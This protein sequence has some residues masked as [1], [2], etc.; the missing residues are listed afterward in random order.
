MRLHPPAM[1]LRQW[2]TTPTRCYVCWQRSVL[3]RAQRAAPACHLWGPYW[4]LWSQRIS[5]RGWFSGTFAVAWT[6]TARVHCSNCLRCLSV[7]P[8]SPC[9]STQPF[10]TPFL[11]SWELVLTQNSA[12]LQLWRT[13]WYCCLTRYIQTYSLFQCVYAVTINKIYFTDSRHP[14]NDK[15]C[16]IFCVKIE[17]MWDDWELK[18]GK[19]G[20]CIKNLSWAVALHETW[21]FEL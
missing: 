4:S 12:V 13:A 7:S 16:F 15:F 9:S 14:T 3:L 1:T 10:S 18:A 6:Q 20:C 21:Q 5:W 2:E 8:S 11:G 19:I 17:W